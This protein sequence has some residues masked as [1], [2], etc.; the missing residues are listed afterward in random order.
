MDNAEKLRYAFG[1]R[2]VLMRAGLAFGVLMSALAGCASQRVAV[3]PVPVDVSIPR[4]QTRVSLPT[5]RVAPPDVL[6]IEAITNIRPANSR[7]QAG[8]SVIVRLQ[9]GLPLQPGI[10]PTHDPLQAEA[11]RQT[12]LQFKVINGPYNVEP[13]GSLNL[14][15]AYG[16]VFVGGLTINE[17]QAALV[18]HFHDRINLTDPKLS[19]MLNDLNGKQAVAGEHL[20][21][22]D[23]TVG[24]GIYGDVN[25][26]GM[27][28]AE[29]RRVLEAHLAKYLQSPQINVDVL[30]YNSRVYY[31]VMDG[32]GYGEQIVRLPCTGNE[33]VLD[34]VAQIDGLSQVSSKRIWVARPCPDSM[35]EAKILNVNWD[36][37]TAGGIA[38]TNY[39]LFP[40]DR[41]YVRA[42]PLIATDNYIAK[43]L[44]PVERIFGTTLLG[45]TT[46]Q[47]LQFYSRGPTGGG[48]F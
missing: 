41:I 5:Y 14:G 18:R 25:V 20:V 23:G 42:D 4:E 16:K 36:A 17:A 47:R 10:D 15:P 26:A 43:L 13:D 9:N 19:I 34:A 44:A 22:P 39:Q 12:E 35:A 21:R 37:I 2:A 46:V 11:Q 24:L 32:G 40:G 3:P 6:L 30:A 7:L 29:V 33:T 48:V 8:D 45:T 1:F 38:T 27:T 28:L 31:I